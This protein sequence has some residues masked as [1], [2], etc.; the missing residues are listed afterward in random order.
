MCYK[1]R[2]SAV[3]ARPA[4]VLSWLRSKLSRP[5]LQGLSLPSEHPPALF[6]A[7]LCALVPVQGRLDSGTVEVVEITFVITFMVISLA[8]HE[9]AHAWVAWKCGDP[10]A[11]DLGRITLNPI[12]S[13]DPF[14]TIILPGA[15]MLMGMT[16]FGGAKPVPVSYHRLRN[17]LR[18]MML[19]ALAGPVTNFLLA[20]LFLLA[21][22]AAYTF[23]DYRPR[24]LMFSVLQ[25]S[26]YANLM[27][28]VFN[29]LPIPPLDGSRVMAWLL[30]AG[31]RETYVGLER[32]GMLLVIGVVVAL[33]QVP[34]LGNLLS[35][36]ALQL[37]NAID[38]LTGG[39][40]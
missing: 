28:T 14:L 9:A 4:P 3:R 30:P 26:V 13:I 17:P 12:A 36:G 2:P 23:G 27:L 35:D 8:L 38:F 19:V 40:W 32:F 10:T 15:M 22:K 21:L 1:T 5:L 33:R 25:M 18:D 39:L 11:K 7:A 34:G 29:L 37:F 6:G 24:D 31:I 20:I 16:P